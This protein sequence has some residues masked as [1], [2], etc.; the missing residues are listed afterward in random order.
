MEIIR[1]LNF[2]A[3]TR[4]GGGVKALRM[5]GLGALVFGL[6]GDLSGQVFYS[7]QRGITSAATGFLWA[8]ADGSWFR[9]SGVVARDSRLVYTAAHVLF[10]RGQ[11]AT[12]YRFIRAYNSYS[13]PSVTGGVAPRGFRYFSN[14][15]SEASR[16]GGSSSRAFHL[17]FAIMYSSSS[18]GTAVGWWDD[19]AAALRSS[20]WKRIAGYPAEVDYTG[21]SGRAYQH[22]TPYFQTTGSQTFGSYYGLRNVSTGS[23][24]SGGP[25]FV[26]DGDADYL[27]GILVSGTSTSA[28]VR[29]IDSSANTMAE[30]ALGSAGGGGGSTPPPSGGGSGGSSGGSDG[31]SGG[32]GGSGR[33]FSN[34][35]PVA[36][37]DASANFTTRSVRVSGMSGR[38]RSLFFTT[39]INTTYRGDLEVYLRSPNG[40]IRWVTRRSGGSADHLRVTN[41]KYNGTFRGVIANGAWSLRMRD[42]AAGD[43]ARFQSFSIRMTSR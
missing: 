39:S 37:P 33:S 2:L 17:D 30:N 32:S 12:G 10:E 4:I 18:F 24:N 13:S 20:R 15:S 8:R 9:G 11:W 28:G 21:A 22:T 41:A 25:V 35:S 5:L 1:R 29:V 26:S 7:Q 3:D 23:G 19:G 16:Y 43:R 14:Y 38:V 36:L 34:R 40:R 6:F 31:G 42:A 27:A